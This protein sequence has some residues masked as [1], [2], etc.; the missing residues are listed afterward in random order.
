MSK[1]DEGKTLS[2]M[3]EALEDLG[4]NVYY[5][6]LNASDFGVPQARKRIY[7]VAFKKYLGVTDFKFPEKI[8]SNI[9]LA[10]IIQDESEIDEYF[11][12]ERPDIYMKDEE[13]IAKLE[14]RKHNEPIRIGTIN[15]GGQ[16][17]R[18]YSING[19][20]ITL[21]AQGGGSGAKTGAYF[22]NGE[23]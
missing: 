17:D 15:K 19:H 4:Y 1:H 23:S 2:Y 3:K 21:S 5:D 6:I 22:V 8:V 16:G 14:A 13:S 18:I 12:I 9:R 11:Y 20:A 7:F 10:D